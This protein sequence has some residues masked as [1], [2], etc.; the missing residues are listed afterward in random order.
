MASNFF[1]FT[2][3]VQR[4]LIYFPT[5]GPL[6]PAA[7]VLPGGE[8]VVLETQDGVRLGAWFVPGTTGPAVLVCNGNGGDRALRAPLAAALAHAGMPVLLF[9][10]RGY[11]DSAGSPTED[12]LADDARAAQAWLAGRSGFFDFRQIWR[13]LR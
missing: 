10:Y 2:A 1:A 9:D 3:P 12:G 8:D 7:A 11:G 13:E 4:R 6:P 5:R